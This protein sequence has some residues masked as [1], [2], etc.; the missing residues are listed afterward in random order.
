MANT[1][2]KRTTKGKP[3]ISNIEKLDNEFRFTLSNI[4][5]PFANGLRRV[6]LTEIPINVVRTESEA[7]NQ[8]KFEYNTCRLHNEILK[9]R[10]SCIPIHNKDLEKLAGKYTIEVD[11][12]NTTDEIQ[13]VTTEDFRLKHKETNEYMS[14]EQTRQIFP[15]DPITH[16]YIDFCRLRP[17]IS[18]TILGEKVKFSADISIATAKDNSMFNVVSKC[19]YQNTPDPEKVQKEWERRELELREKYKT[20]TQEEVQFEKRNFELL[21]AE[22]FFVPNSF[23]YTISSIGIYENEELVKKACM[24]LHNKIVDFIKA[25][26]DNEVPI[27]LSETSMDNCYDIVLINEDYT[28]G[29]ILELVLY[30]RYYHT[31]SPADK[32]L[33]FISF[34]KYHPHNLESVLRLA[35]TEQVKKEQIRYVLKECAIEAQEKVKEMYDL[36]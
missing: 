20:I 6:I 33:N 29:K 24:I 7:I 8:C 2:M 16:R 4:D 17:K 35:F 28:L 18:D 3:Q 22:R 19:T 23:D 31:K 13:Y 30:D 11:K 9:Q 36:F 5:T 15:A 21:D 34:K 25:L 26:T 12:E 32:K 1:Q 10:L 14:K 27:Q